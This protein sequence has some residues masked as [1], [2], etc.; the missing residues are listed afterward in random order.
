ML[1]RRWCSLWDAREPGVGGIAAAA[2]SSAGSHDGRVLWSSVEVRED[3]LEARASAG[4]HLVSRERIP[5]DA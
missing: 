5:F 2:R 1:Q 3:E 4:E